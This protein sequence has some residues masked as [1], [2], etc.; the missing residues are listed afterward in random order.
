[1]HAFHTNK[2]TLTTQV[3]D[4]TTSVKQL[5]ADTMSTNNGILL[6][7]MEEALAAAEIITARLTAIWEQQ[8][9]EGDAHSEIMRIYDGMKS[10]SQ[11]DFRPTLNLMGAHVQLPS[12]FVAKCAREMGMLWS[13]V[14]D[15]FAMHGQDVSSSM[16]EMMEYAERGR[17]LFQGTKTKRVCLFVCVIDCC[18]IFILQ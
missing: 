3:S 4:M 6:I 14:V 8:L 7:K 16:H 9:V 15:A 18:V 5:R 11:G 1:M 17:N 13:L 12:L 10:F 2:R